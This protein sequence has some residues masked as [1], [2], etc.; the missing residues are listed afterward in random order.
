MPWRSVT[1]DHCSVSVPGPRLGPLSSCQWPRG[2]ETAES[3]EFLQRCRARVFGWIRRPGPPKGLCGHPTPGRE[4]SR[5]KHHK[6]GGTA[7]PMWVCS[8]AGDGG[9]RVPFVRSQLTA[10]SS[11][12]PGALFFTANWTFRSER[13]NYSPRRRGLA[14]NADVTHNVTLP[15][16][17]APAPQLG[18]R[19]SPRLFLIMEVTSPQNLLMISKMTSKKAPVSRIFF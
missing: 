19:P 5:N 14:T 12:L 11:V 17:G 15:V 9:S 1:G 18:S 8:G 7:I 16:T 2:R 6:S 13:N 3:A 4:G 10:S